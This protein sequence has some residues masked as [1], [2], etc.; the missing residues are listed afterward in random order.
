MAWHT[1]R[2]KGRFGPRIALI[3]AILTLVVG[4]VGLIVALAL[5][6]FVF[7]EFDAYGEVPVPGSGRI[8]CPPVR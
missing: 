2:M 1:S 7:D 5:S 6:A 8:R 3:S 4:V